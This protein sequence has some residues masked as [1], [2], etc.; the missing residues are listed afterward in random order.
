MPRLFKSIFIS[1]T[2]LTAGM[3]QADNTV[4]KAAIA[5]RLEGVILSFGIANRLA[6]MCAEVEVNIKAL[7][8]DRARVMDVAKGHFSSQDELM[9]AAGM[10]EQERM[11]EMLRAFFFDRGV[12][13]SSPAQEYCRL[14]K[15]L[16]A[17]ED[18][19]ANYFT[20]RKS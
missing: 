12:S 5:Q 15:T 17:V 3:A 11:G 4:E 10:S 7:N 9:Q 8:A 2:L 16:V 19:Q 13:W 20:V 18:H 14:A 1:I 6:E